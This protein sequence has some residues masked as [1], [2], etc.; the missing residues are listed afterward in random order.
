MPNDL[1]LRISQ[2]ISVSLVFILGSVAGYLA[3]RRGVY[4][5]LPLLVTFF[6]LLSYYWLECSKRNHRL[7]TSLMTLLLLSIAAFAY[8]SHL[9][10]VF[11]MVLTG[12]IALFVRKRYVRPFSDWHRRTGIVVGGYCILEIAFVW[13]YLSSHVMG[14]TFLIGLLVLLTL[15][16]QFYFF[17]A[18][19]KGRLFALT[20]I[21]FHLLYFLS[22]GLA[23]MLALVRHRVGK[24]DDTMALPGGAKKPADG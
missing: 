20:A 8:Y 14:V 10:F 19:H 12:W 15:N 2:R 22:S 13:L 1:N 24:M 4:F 5:L 16:Q 18:G 21:P 7:I 3:L 17:L 9:A 23:V 6:I 11:P